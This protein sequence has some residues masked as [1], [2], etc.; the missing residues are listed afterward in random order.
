MLHLRPRLTQPRA[1]LLRFAW[2]AVAGLCV[3]LASPWAHAGVVVV[4]H[5]SVRKLDPLMV[6]RIYTGRMVE[7][8]GQ[9]LLPVNYPAGNVLRQRFLSDFLQQDEDRYTAYW[10]VRRYVG[11]GVPPR[12]LST[13][14]ETILYVL[15]TPG[16]VAYLDESDVPPGMNVVAGRPAAAP[17][18]R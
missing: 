12:E 16:A 10:T 17:S 4:A 18:P 11:K 3:W 8:G 13:S 6:Q 14:G 9:A 2:L 5:A 7:A 1:H 15:N